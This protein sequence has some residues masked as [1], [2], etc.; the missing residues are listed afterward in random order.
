MNDLN[1]LDQTLAVF[2]CVYLWSNPTDGC[3]VRL[4]FS[5]RCD[6]IRS[7]RNVISFSCVPA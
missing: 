5:V 2:V 6:L 3:A 1:V 7:G 4:S